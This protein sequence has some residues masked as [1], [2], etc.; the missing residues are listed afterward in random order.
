MTE[1]TRLR[2]AEISDLPFIFRRERE[3]I[4]T[5]EPDAL[6]GWLAA[7]DLNLEF[8]IECLSG[9]L[10]CVDDQGQPLGYAMWSLDGDAATLVSINVL[11]GRR[12]QGLGRLLLDAFEETVRAGGARVVELGVHRTNQAHLLYRASGYETTGQ[13]GEYVLFS[14]TLSPAEGHHRALLG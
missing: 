1:P 3:Y 2:F 12:R 10:F 5:V 8:W 9:T 4:E 14:K 11:A 13:D 7:L 6:E